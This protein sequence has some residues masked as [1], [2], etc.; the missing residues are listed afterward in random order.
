V[1]QAARPNR[2]LPESIVALTIA[3]TI[4]LAV[5]AHAADAPGAPGEPPSD[6][7]RMVVEAP[8]PLK[9]TL[10]RDVGLARWQA[11]AGMTEDLL[12]RLAREAI[13]E[14]RQAAAAEGWFS[15]EIDVTIDRRTKPPTVTLSV[16]PGEPTLITSVNIEVTGPATTDVPRG[17]DAIANLKH[18]WG[19]PVGARFRQP[20]WTAAKEAALATLTASPYAAAKITHSEASIDPPNYSAQLALELTSGP[21]FRFGALEITGLSRYPESIVRNFGTI[22]RGAPYEESELV[23]FVR[24]L[25]ASGYFASAQAAIDADPA[26]ADDATI[27]VAVIEAPTRRFEA[28]LGYSTDVQFRGNASYRDVDFNGHGLQMLIEGRLE[29]KLQSM[30]LRFTQPPN[31]SGWIGTYLASAERTDIES[32]VTRTAAAGTRWHTI[33][34]RN[35]HALSAT[36]YVDQQ[37]PAGAEWIKS[38]AT[39]LA[40]ER[41][42]RRT[43]NLISPTT[44][45]MASLEGGGGPPGVSTLGF[46]RVVGRFASWLPIDDKNEFQFRAQGGAVLA[47]TRVGIPSVLLFRTGGDTTVRGYAFESLGVQDGSAIVPGRYYAVFNGEVTHW[48]TEAWGIAA[49]VD[50]GNAVDSLSNAH[51]ALGYGVGARVR[52]PLGPFRVDLAYGQDVHKFRVH[53]SIGLTF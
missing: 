50:A 39:Y 5:D 42:W 16:T 29:S 37:Q 35:E 47:T 11:Y 43:D 36:F 20:A 34:E 6:A 49:F 25:N 44:G 15:A 10:M 24:R 12:D 48:I 22:E 9:E 8:S 13:G 1:P 53:L 26:H 17:T 14:T 41:F 52:S 46:G 19:L 2:T 31:E 45:W 33:E 51:L 3:T 32:L 30:S 23:R 21:A 38:H 27:K 18:N 28:G 40:Y 4:L 7:Y